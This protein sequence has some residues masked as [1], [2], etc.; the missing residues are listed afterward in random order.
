MNSV[1]TS[2]LIQAVR[3]PI[4]LITLG[5]LVAL[6]NVSGIS[7]VNRT[8][9]VLLIVFGLL[10]LLEKSVARSSA[11]AEMPYPQPITSDYEPP[12]PRPGGQ[13]L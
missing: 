7:F 1:L 12:T 8:W 10:K 2:D 11:P 4:M 9:P 6:D 3:G 13:P 5:G